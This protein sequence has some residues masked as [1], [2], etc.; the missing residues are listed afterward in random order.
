MEKKVIYNNG[1]SE[2][3][4]KFDGEI[5]TIEQKADGVGH[6]S[7][8]MYEDELEDIYKFVK[9]NAPSSI[10]PN[11]KKRLKHI[12]RKVQEML[13]SADSEGYA[14]VNIL[15]IYNDMI[16]LIEQAEKVEQLEERIAEGVKSHWG[17]APCLAYDKLQ[18]KVERYEK[19]LENILISPFPLD[20]DDAVAIAKQALEGEK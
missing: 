18:A 7:I 19:A 5:V 8:F 2:L 11:D 14:E 20:I 4:V 3:S 12:E 15:A 6:N 1:N 10:V 9:E 13:S 16:W 17:C